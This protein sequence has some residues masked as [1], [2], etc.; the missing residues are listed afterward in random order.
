MHAYLAVAFMLLKHSFALCMISVHRLS[1]ID[2][3][4]ILRLIYED[5]F[6]FSGFVVDLQIKHSA[7]E[8]LAARDNGTLCVGV[9]L[10]QNLLRHTMAL[11]YW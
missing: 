4:F 3:S 5:R 2:S 7:A 8:S 10:F 11:L 9:P 1:V 6:Q